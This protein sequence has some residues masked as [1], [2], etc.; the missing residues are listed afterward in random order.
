MLP[1][2]SLTASQHSL[3]LNWFDSRTTS[4]KNSQTAF[5]LHGNQHCEAL[6]IV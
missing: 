3:M 4:K 6:R 2:H 1:F 5:K